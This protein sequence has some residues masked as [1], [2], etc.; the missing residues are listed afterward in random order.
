MELTFLEASEPLTKSI[1]LADVKPYPHAKLLTS[2]VEDVTTPFDFFD[3]IKDHAA[4]G[5][6]LLKGSLVRN[7]RKESRAG[8]TDTQAETHWLCLDVDGLTT[9]T[10][11]QLIKQLGWEDQTYVL[12][13]SATSG[14]FKNTSLKA[15]LF[16]M[17]SEPI[18]PDFMQDWLMWMNL[19]LFDKKISLNP[20]GITL[21]YPLDIS[22]C[23]NSRIIF[24]APPVF[25]DPSIDPYPGTRISVVKKKIN[26]LD[27]PD[28]AIIPPRGKLKTK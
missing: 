27:P 19:E 20:A 18:S 9:T 10:V 5:H 7:I 15:H 11:N 22:I 14:L 24:V 17:L 16:F 1:S 26:L 25:E 13:Y 8:L 28:P 4:L 23:Q 12:Q 21:H 6:A 2:Y 3:A